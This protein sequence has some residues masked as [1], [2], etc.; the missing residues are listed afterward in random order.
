MSKKRSAVSAATA[1]EMYVRR[2]LM[3]VMGGIGGD[4]RRRYDPQNNVMSA[5][6]ASTLEYLR[7]MAACVNVPYL[8]ANADALV[9]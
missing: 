2:W 7:A 4:P 5:C 8:W 6:M 1:L 3:W 9:P